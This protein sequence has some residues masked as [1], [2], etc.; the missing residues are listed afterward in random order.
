MSAYASTAQVQSVAAARSGLAA[1]CAAERRKLLAQ[2]WTRLAAIACALGPLLVALLLSRQS[3]APGD[4]LLGTWVHSSGWATGFVT[5]DFAGYLGFPVLAALVAGDLFSCEDRYG[6]WKAILTRSSGRRDVF[7]AKVLAGAVLAS[8]LTVLVAVS[9]VAGGL[10]FVG[11][12]PLVG[13][14]G[15]VLGSREAALLLVSS[16]LLSI[17]PVIGFVSLAVLLSVA[18]RSGIVGVAGTAIAGLLMQL[19]AFVGNGSWTGWTL[20]GSAFDGWHGLLA[21]PRY[22]A[23]LAIAVAVSTL[24]TAGALSAAWLILSRRDFAGPPVTRLRGW[25]PSLRTTGDRRCAGAA[26]AGRRAQRRSHDHHQQKAGGLNHSELPAA[27]GAAAARARSSRAGES[28]LRH[29]DELCQARP[30]RRRTWRRLAV[31]DDP[32]VCPDRLRPARTA[33]GVI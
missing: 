20:L 24:W 22:Y 33:A 6:T 1:A 9:S 28:A 23:P 12:R 32:V 18:S 21:S 31:H 10:L 15:S 3:G 26:R 2:T 25:A 7:V 13:V 4:S 17:P 16:W 27:D 30:R 19:L 5:L 11:S 29:E 8:A 14:G